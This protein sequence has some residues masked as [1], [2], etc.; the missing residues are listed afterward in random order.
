MQARQNK[1]TINTQLNTKPELQHNDSA[2]KTT[3]ESNSSSDVILVEDLNKELATKFEK[4]ILKPYFKNLFKD[5]SLRS[6]IST[7]GGV[8]VDKNAFIE[9][10]NLPGIVSDRL[11]ALAYHNNKEEKIEQDHFVKLMLDV[12]SAELDDKMNIAFKIFDFN[13]DGL[14]QAEDVRMIISF[15]PKNRE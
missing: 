8:F 11:F 14:I 13:S 9:Y 6:S 4:K 7:S 2:T 5:L 3:N 1:L 10:M 12:Y 15:I